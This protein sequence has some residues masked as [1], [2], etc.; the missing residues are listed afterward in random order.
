[1]SV[2]GVEI[3]TVRRRRRPPE[4]PRVLALSARGV[5]ATAFGALVLVG[6]SFSAGLIKGERRVCSGTD[7]LG[8]PL[9]TP[10]ER[11]PSR[12]AGVTS[13]DLQAFEAANRPLAAA[14]RIA[15]LAE[16]PPAPV[17]VGVPADPQPAEPAAPALV[18]HKEAPAEGR[19]G[20]QLG[21]FPSSAE[22]EAFVLAH[23]EAIGT[24]PVFVIP[25]E[26]KERGTWYRVRIGALRSKELA[27][28]LR[29]RLPEELGR[30]AMVVSHR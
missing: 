27:E 4:A 22:A 25:T 30:G 17:L 3:Q 1:V 12:A 21:A 9:G 6:L 5:T 26:I 2:E 7:L 24:A 19:Y 10:L 13:T 16:T 11:M 28:A 20:V 23:Q 8:D 14:Q 18:I 29:Q 15:P